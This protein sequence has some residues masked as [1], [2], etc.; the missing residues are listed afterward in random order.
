[1][2]Q[3]D[4][5]EIISLLTKRGSILQAVDAD[6]IGKRELVD[7]LVVSRSTVDRGIRELEAAG[8]LARSADGYRRTLLGELLLTEYD[9]FTTQ[10]AAL[11]AG[12]ELLAELAPDY[13]LDPVVFE[14][15][16][17]ITASKH[18]PHQPISAFCSLINEARWTQSVFPAV[19]PQVLD[20]WVELCD[21][22]MI[23]ADIILSEPAVG[24]LVS[25]HADSLE[26]LLAESRIGLHQVDSGPTCGLVVA[27]DDTT[28]TGG[29]VVLDNR[30]SARAYIETDAEMAVSWLRDRI[31][32]HLMQ[33]TPLAGQP[34]E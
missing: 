26:T 2:T 27:E 8:L 16:T 29:L 18:D 1:M 25:S 11:L 33:S 5:T 31:T 17:I 3:H 23:R 10:T 19:F 4:S 6:G 13:E 22:E 28:A 12:Q 30:G 9:Q 21:N 15:A 24:T 20:Q 34:A 32:D 7:Q 14:N